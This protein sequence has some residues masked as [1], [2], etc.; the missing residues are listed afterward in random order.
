MHLDTQAKKLLGQLDMGCIASTAYDTAW[1]ARLARFGH[2]LGERALDWLLVHQ[3]P[4]GS[5]GSWPQFVIHD[6]IMCT[7]AA[8]VALAEAPNARRYQ[9]AIQRGVQALSIL[10]GKARQEEVVDVNRATVGFEMLLPTLMDEARALGILPSK[11]ERVLGLV[12]HLGERKRRKIRNVPI[13]REVSMVFSAEMAGREYRGWLD[14]QNL[15][16]PN[17]SVGNSPSATAYYLLCVNPNDTQAWKYLEKA[18]NPDGGFPLAHPM[19]AFERSWV[20]WNLGLVE[21]WATSMHADFVSLLALLYNGWHSQYGIG[22]STFGSLYDG[23][24]TAMATALLR[25]Y[26]WEVDLSPMFFYETEGY[27]ITYPMEV[28]VSYTTNIHALWALSSLGF[29]DRYPAVRKVISL[30]TQS[31]SIVPYDKWHASPF[32]LVSHQVIA[33]LTYETMR[34]FLQKQVDWIL[35]MQR[36]DGAWGMKASTIEETALCLQAL[37]VWQRTVGNIPLENI[38][39]GAAWLKR[40]ENANVPAMWVAKTLYL[41]AHVVR[42]SV[43]SALALAESV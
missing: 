3:N 23:D 18:V 20:V 17:G 15:R 42:S 8:V 33:G 34:P 37:C 41:P 25:R 22:F 39:R 36:P 38:R 29:D 26:G 7:L 31:S 19:E 32:Y 16:N 10:G 2:P 40:R 14:Q 5:W 6:H 9:R 12:E 21:D 28:G 24:D 1:V 4:D 13:N 30:L 43:L 27:F 11:A 35:S